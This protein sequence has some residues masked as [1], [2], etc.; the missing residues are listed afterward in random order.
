MSI[1][2]RIK[3]FFT[4]KEHKLAARLM[5]MKLAQDTHTYAI[6]D[7]IE[8]VNKNDDFKHLV[9]GA[10]SNTDSRIKELE[11]KMEFMFKFASSQE[12]RV[13]AL[14]ERVNSE[15]LDNLV[16]TATVKSPQN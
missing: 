13:D 2:T 3:N 6:A 5:I 16:H 12:D 11:E 1:W 15:D 14:E 7:L 10:V 8:R 9:A 4:P